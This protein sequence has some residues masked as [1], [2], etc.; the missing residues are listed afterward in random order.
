MRRFLLLGLI[1]GF[2]TGCGTSTPPA[3][4]NKD[5]PKTTSQL[6][7]AGD[8]IASR[9]PSPDQ[10]EVA[11]A[12]AASPQRGPTP[13]RD[14]LSAE[15]MAQVQKLEELTAQANAAQARFDFA[16]AAG[17]W[18]SAMELLSTLYGPQAWPTTNARLAAE[19]ASIQSKFTSTQL[20]AVK[21]LYSSQTEIARLLKESRHAPALELAQQSQRITAE[22]FGPGSW[23]M[24]KQWVQV[25]RLQQLNNQPEAA[26]A[27]Y[28]EAILLHDQFL[29]EVHPDKETLH[30]YLGEAFLAAGQNRPA[31]D[32][33]SKAALIAQRLWGDSSLKYA[34]RAND[35][36]VAY[37]RA[38]DLETAIRVFRAAES[39]RRRELGMDDPLVAHCL[40]NLGT[41]Y[42]ELSRHELAV[43]CFAQ[44]LPIL[45]AKLGVGSRMVVEGSLRYTAA[46]VLAGQSQMAER[47]LGEL[48]AALADRPGTSTERAVAQYRLA[49]LQAKQ[50][51][52]ALA[53]PN[54]KEAIEVQARLLG[55]EHPTTELSKQ[56]LVKVYEQTGRGAEA[57]TLQSQIRQVQYVEEDTQFKQR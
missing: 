42:M 51:N 26:I 47:I 52:Y 48:V 23:M 2:F 39:I 15:A 5:Q 55:S 7:P 21:E 50:G 56:A 20:Q 53:E 3:E 1:T 12:P 54:L 33:L 32:N 43:Q 49:I 4:T 30:A 25:A 22:L 11:T 19:T 34:T 45:Q 6:K 9:S 41:V 37:Q 35:L 46:L 36:G 16:S 17:H 44:A 38:G 10:A 27:S 24:G 40:L 29:G 57:Q 13:E 28:R 31:V 8:A 14:Q 18:S